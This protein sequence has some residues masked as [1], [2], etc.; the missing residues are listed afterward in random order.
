MCKDMQHD[1]YTDNENSNL[2]QIEQRFK[3][4]DV[5]VLNATLTLQR[6]E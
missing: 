2:F 1:L 3:K 6:A 5:E 4:T